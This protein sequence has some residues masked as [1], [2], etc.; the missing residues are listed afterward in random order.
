MTTATMTTRRARPPKGYRPPAIHFT[1]EHGRKCVRVPLDSYGRNYAVALERDYRAVRAT[2]ATGTWRLNANDKGQHY[3]RTAVP[4][5][6]GGST[7]VQVAR[8]MAH[9]T[10]RTAIYYV[11]KDRLDLRP[12]NFFYGK[13]PRPRR[14]DV[15]LAERGARYRKERQQQREEE[16][17]RGAAA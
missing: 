3:V 6:K 12:E 1:D 8:L 13:N 10:A 15:K 16:A 7:V 2:G 4:D 11:N 9:A 14:C 5:G 17:Q